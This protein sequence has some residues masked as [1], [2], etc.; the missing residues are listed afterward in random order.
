MT[1]D[2]QL[3]PT[4]AE[5]DALVAAYLGDCGP[6]ATRV[7]SFVRAVLA[8]WGT[9][10]PTQAQEPVAWL[11]PWRADKVTTDYDAYGERG[12][13]LYTAPQPAPAPLSECL[14]LL[15]SFEYEGDEDSQAKAFFKAHINEDWFFH[16]KNSLELA[17]AAQGG[18]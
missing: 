16:V 15:N 1:T 2:T 12:I 18:K 7:Y 9:P 13:P 8:K 3:T 17:L 14:R 11:N 5:I 4:D 6:Q 10:Q